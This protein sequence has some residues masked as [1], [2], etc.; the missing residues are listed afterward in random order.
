MPFYRG[1]VE[2]EGDDLA[3]NDT[4]LQIFAIFQANAKQDIM[5]RL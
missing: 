1:D 2:G 3:R 5:R 4:V